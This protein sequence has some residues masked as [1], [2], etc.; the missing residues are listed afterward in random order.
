MAGR[1]KVA[2][3]GEQK[4][5]ILNYVEGHGFDAAATMYP[6]ITKL[7]VANWKRFANPKPTRK[8]IKPGTVAFAGVT[9]EELI[10][11]NQKLRSCLNI[12]LGF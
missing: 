1:K 4:G 3:T 2:Y 7:L 10:A 11:E 6:G 5:E 8:V 12:M 9:N